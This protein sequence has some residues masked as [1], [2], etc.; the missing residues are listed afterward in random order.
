V[1]ESSAEEPSDLVAAILADLETRTGGHATFLVASEP[2]GGDFPLVLAR[3]QAQIR[4]Q[5][6]RMPTV[7]V[8]ADPHDEPAKDACFLDGWRPAVVPYRVDPTRPDLKVSRA[9]DFRRRYGRRVKNEIFQTLLGDPTYGEDLVAKDLNRLAAD[10]SRGTLH[11][12][13]ALIHIDGNSF[14]KVRRKLC[15]TP[16]ARADFD[17]EIQ[18]GCREL[19]LLSLL[20]HAKGDPALQ[21]RDDAGNTALRIEI[22]LWGGDEMT[23]VVPAWRGW[24]TLALYYQQANL[25]RFQ[26]HELSQRAA[27]IFCHHNAPILQI[28]RL[29]DELL[30]RTR[31]DIEH[32]FADALQN[33]AD[34]AHLDEA[35]RPQTLAWLANH[36]LGNAIHYL[37]LKSFDMLGG[38]LDAFLQKYYAHS[39]Y[40]DLLLYAHELGRVGEHLQKLH[41]HVA[42]GKVL[43]IVQALHMQDETRLT[44]VYNRLLQMTDSRQRQAVTASLAALVAEKPGRWQ[45]IADLWD[46]ATEWH[47]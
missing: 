41:S 27:I 14:G 7:R 22:L 21:A 16:K 13:I 12:K 43:E 40:R 20:D 29:A 6:W 33:H 2:D 35:A 36:A 32:N 37:S 45:M 1:V 8:P 11:G 44:Q 4:R 25:L 38:S 39:D 28:R 17:E 10:P 34:F 5:Q 23:L 3:L 26:G 9:T 46:F 30:A 42:K 15:T 24:K 19:F 31:A 18:Q 47:A